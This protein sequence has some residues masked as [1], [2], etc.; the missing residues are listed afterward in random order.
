MDNIVAYNPRNY[1]QSKRRYDDNRFSKTD[2]ILSIDPSLNS[3][4][5][6]DDDW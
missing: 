6:E 5:Y 2:L 4:Y 3:N 1:N